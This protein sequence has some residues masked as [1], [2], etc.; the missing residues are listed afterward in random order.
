[1]KHPRYPRTAL[2]LLLLA[3]TVGVNAA[4]PLYPLGI[5]GEEMAF[6]IDVLVG[7]VVTWLWSYGLAL[8]VGW[9]VNLRRRRSSRHYVR[10]LGNVA[11][12]HDAAGRPRNLTPDEDGF[13]RRK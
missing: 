7:T 13:W 8:V 5:S 10:A 4:L 2:A 9:T 12:Q 6:G 3:V 1:M 11:D